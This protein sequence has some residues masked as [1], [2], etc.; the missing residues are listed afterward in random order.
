MS[1]VAI[2]KLVLKSIFVRK[3]TPPNVAIM[4]P[5]MISKISK[6]KKQTKKRPFKVPK[7]PKI[8]KNPMYNILF[9]KP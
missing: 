6:L 8:K 7:I 4:I 1:H 5:K 2:R 3:R 9:W